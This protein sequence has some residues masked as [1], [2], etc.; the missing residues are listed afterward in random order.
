MRDAPPA[1]GLAEGRALRFVD[2][3]VRRGQG[4]AVAPE[5]RDF[6]GEDLCLDPDWS[7]G[8]VRGT[9]YGE[10]DGM[11]TFEDTE[12]TVKGLLGQARQ[13]GVITS[14]IGDAGISFAIDSSGL[15]SWTVIPDAWRGFSLCDRA[16]EELR[17]LGIESAAD[18]GLASGAQ[19]AM[20]ILRHARTGASA[21]IRE[22]HAYYSRMLPATRRRL[23]RQVRTAGRPRHR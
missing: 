3:A 17:K 23:P 1:F 18:S 19:T 16:G 22:H 8:S 2:R 20:A 11:M 9:V 5:E 12:D 6:P 21:I 14:T 10:I 13:A 7:L 15:F 4:D